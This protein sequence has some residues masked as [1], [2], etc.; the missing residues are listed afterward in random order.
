M[1]LHTLNRQPLASR[2]D[3]KSTDQRWLTESGTP[4]GIRPVELLT[5]FGSNLNSQVSINPVG[6]LAI[7]DPSFIFQYAMEERIAI[8]GVLFGQCCKALLKGR[9]IAPRGAL[10]SDHR[11]VRLQ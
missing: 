3:T 11:T 1:M 10:I 8:T 4:T 2:S 7:G 6:S 9:I 5:P